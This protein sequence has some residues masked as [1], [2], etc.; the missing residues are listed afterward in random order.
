MGRVAAVVIGLACLLAPALPASAEWLADVYLGY[1]LVPDKQDIITG[2]S[3]GPATFRDVEFD[4]SFTYGGRFGKYFDWAPFFGVAVDFSHFAPRISPQSIT[5]DGCLAGGG[6]AQGRTIGFGSFDVSTTAISLDLMFR[7]PLW[8]TPDM[9][10]GRIQPY[11]GGG[12]PIFIT[13]VHPHNTRF[14]RNH[15]DDT[16]IT[17]GYKGIAGVGFYVARNLVMFTEYRYSHFEPEVELRDSS[18]RRT[19]FRTEIDSHT[20]LIGIGARW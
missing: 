9:P 5:V 16:G 17:W 1:T 8:S 18:A 19:N 4:D 20:G 6:C 12:T 11:I 3:R 14:F 13:T 10:G 15:D 7:L 2:N